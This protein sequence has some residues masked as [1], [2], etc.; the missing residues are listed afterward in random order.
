MK[1]RGSQGA[2]RFEPGFCAL[3]QINNNEEDR[4]ATLIGSDQRRL[5]FEVIFRFGFSLPNCWKIDMFSMLSIR[6]MYYHINRLKD[7]YMIKSINEI[8]A[9]DK[10]LKPFMIKL[11]KNK[12]EKNFTNLLKRICEVVEVLATKEIRQQ[13]EIKTIQIG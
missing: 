5:T 2:E 4:G 6:S 7:N 11:L 1:G 10:N 3:S 12:I 9:F 13:K 8:I